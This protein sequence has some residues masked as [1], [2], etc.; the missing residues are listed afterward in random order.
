MG[1]T[2]IVDA[3]LGWCLDLWESYHWWIVIVGII[4]IIFVVHSNFFNF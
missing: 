2:D 1:I 4:A 3:S